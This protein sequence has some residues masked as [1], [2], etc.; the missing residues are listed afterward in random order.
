MPIKCCIIVAF[1]ATILPVIIEKVN[2]HRGYVYLFVLKIY[3][4]KKNSKLNFKTNAKHQK[5]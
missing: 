5:G 1:V 4:E 3:E 2:K